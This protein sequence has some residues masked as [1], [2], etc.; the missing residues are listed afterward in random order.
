MERKWTLDEIAREAA[1][2]DW[3]KVDALTDD[4]IIAAAKAD[5]DCVLPTEQELAQFDLVIPAK[6]R[7][8]RPKE[9]AE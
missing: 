8:P 7:L 2:F 5:P 3:T 9:A 6:S 4:E 1:S